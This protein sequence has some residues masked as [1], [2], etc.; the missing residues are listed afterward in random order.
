MPIEN[1]ALMSADDSGAYSNRSRWLTI[2]GLALITIVGAYLRLAGLDARTVGHLEMYVPGIH[3]PRGISVP[4]ERLTLAKVLTGT[5][6]TDT[7]PPAYYIFMWC[8]TKCFGT[9]VWAIRLPSALFGIACIPLVFWLAT[10]IHRRRDRWIAAILV[11]VSGQ[12]V[13]WSQLARMYILACFLGL[14][15][16]ILLTKLAQSDGR[17]RF[18]EFPYVLVILAGLATHIFFWTLFGT[19]ILWT[20]LNAWGQHL[21]LPGVAKSQILALILG[22][23]LLAFAAYQSGGTL[24]LSGNIP[25]YLREYLQFSF[26]IPEAVTD[27][28]YVPMA[29]WLLLFLAVLLFAFGIASMNRPGNS[30]LTEVRGPSTWQWGLAAILSTGAVLAFVQVANSYVKPEPHP[31]LRITEKMIL[32]PVSDGKVRSLR[33]SIFALVTLPFLHYS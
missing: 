31:T 13:C 30:L 32:L 26:M 17:F 27:N 1:P 8:W 21:P 11:A 15:A 18:L 3:L 9:G 10:L 25:G 16:T 33:K 24:E 2:G 19:H 7:H 5:F 29:G 12:N 4:E 23:P 14:L 22:S 6:S 20:F 28:R